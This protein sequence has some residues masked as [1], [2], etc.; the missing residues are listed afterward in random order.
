MPIGPESVRWV[1]FTVRFTSKSVHN[2]LISVLFVLIF[3]RTDFEVDRTVE[4]THRTDSGPMDIR[5][6]P[7]PLAEE[8]WEHYSG[9]LNP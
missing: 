5:N 2:T 6:P 7:L 4:I 1:I 3:V 9:F 8:K